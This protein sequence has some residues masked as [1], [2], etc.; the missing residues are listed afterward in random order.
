MANLILTQIKSLCGILENN[1]LLLS[2]AQMGRLNCIENAFLVIKNGLIESYGSMSDFNPSKWADPS[3][4]WIQ[5]EGKFVLPC[6]VDSHTH[7]V[8]AKTREEE[9]VMRIKGKSY[10]EIAEAGGGILN[11]AK[12]LQAMSEEELFTLAE[13]RLF[14]V[15]SYGTGAIE[16]KSGYGL[17]VADEIKMLRVIKRL[18]AISPIPIKAT[19]LGAHAFPKEYKENHQGYIKLIIDEML[20]VVVAE[21]LADYMD[22]FC[23]QGFFNVEE[24]DQLLKAA[25]HYNLKAKIHGNELGFTGGVQV[26][27]KNNA[28]SVDHLEY[29][30]DAEIESLLNSNTMPVALPGCSFFLGIPYAPARKMIDAGLPVC[31]AS[32]YNP[33]STPNGRMGF[34]VALACSQMKLSP[35]EAINATTI[36]GAYS[37]ELSNQ[38]GSITVGKIGNVILTKPMQSLAIM[39]YFF[40]VDQVEKA[41]ISGKI[42]GSNQ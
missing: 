42:F 2:G 31:L 6:F 38:L 8:F 9:F 29:T 40:G 30:G 26:A 10:E 15:I 21:N 32:D 35:E 17:T 34:V 25:A 16:I 41:I 7:I 36:N 39:P 23:D 37:I 5:A 20:P 19:F 3:F 27:V 1:E 33:G 18:K 12:R 11:S 4:E 28:L 14:E 22:V 13:K 24:C